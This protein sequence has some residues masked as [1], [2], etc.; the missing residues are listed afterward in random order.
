MPV[1]NAEAFLRSVGGSTVAGID[2]MMR[3][4][5]GGGLTIIGWNEL[6]CQLAF[7]HAIGR[8]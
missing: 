4:N 1:Y 3:G 6:V 8:I 2:N 5:M 7:L